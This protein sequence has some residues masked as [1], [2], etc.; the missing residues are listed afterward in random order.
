[1]HLFPKSISKMNLNFME[2]ILKFIFLSVSYV[3]Y[4]WKY[5]Q[6]LSTATFYVVDIHLYLCIIHHLHR[7]WHNKDRI[8]QDCSSESRCRAFLA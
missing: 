7:K 2:R 8:D 4:W 5:Q 1:M 6:N 3:S